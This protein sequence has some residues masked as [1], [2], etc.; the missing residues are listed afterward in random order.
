MCLQEEKDKRKR[1]NRSIEKARTLFYRYVEKHGNGLTPTDFAKKFGWDITQ[2][3]NDIK[4]SY[5][6]QC[7]Y[8]NQPYKDMGHGLRDITLDILNPTESPYYTTNVGYCC[9]SCNRRKDRMG[10]AAFAKFLSSVKRRREFLNSD[11]R[12]LP[13]S[14]YR[15][16]LKFDDCK[17]V[18][19]V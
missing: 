3:A 1:Q 17:E 5:K 2:I 12:T 15:M 14:Q 6:G 13:K 7:P 10:P 9:N 18:L 8:C 19:N 4:R 11:Y 16:E